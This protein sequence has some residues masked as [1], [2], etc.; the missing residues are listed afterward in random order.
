MVFC[1]MIF[2]FIKKNKKHNILITI[3]FFSISILFLSNTKE[4]KDKIS[5]ITLNL[6]SIFNK[7]FDSQFFEKNEG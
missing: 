3:I 1:I 5:E 2:N 7:G 6:S 4:S